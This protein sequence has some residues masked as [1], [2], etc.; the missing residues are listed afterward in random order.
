[1]LTLIVKNS[2]HTTA[3]GFR[4]R[5]AREP[6]AVLSWMLRMFFAHIFPFKSAASLKAAPLV[7]T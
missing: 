2:Q 4:C 7:L 3:T 6:F 1:M 5:D